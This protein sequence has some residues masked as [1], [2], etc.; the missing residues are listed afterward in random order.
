ML[1]FSCDQAHEYNVMNLI[2]LSIVVF[3][4]W[5]RLLARFVE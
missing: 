2:N 4:A 1:S 3:R 5:V